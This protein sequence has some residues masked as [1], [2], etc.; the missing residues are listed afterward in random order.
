MATKGKLFGVLAEFETA[1]SI[2]QASERIRDAGFKR[3]DT[4]TPFPVHNLDHAMG[5]KPSRLP[6]LVLVLGFAGAAGAFWLQAWVHVVEY[7]LTIAAKPYFAWQAFIPVTFEVGVLFGAL[8]AVFGMFAFNRLP[9]LYHPLFKSERFNRASDDRFFVS[10]E[11]A[12]PKFHAT[13][14]VKFLTELGATHVELV[15]D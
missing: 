11:A 1:T 5:L 6:W 2:Y 10:I 12:D 8:A 9:T 3:W 7:P 4:H 15:E 13:S 14:T